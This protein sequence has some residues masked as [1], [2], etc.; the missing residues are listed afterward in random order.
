MKNR[1]TFRTEYITYVSVEHVIC[2]PKSDIVDQ[3]V[4][5]CIYSF[6]NQIN[7]LP[8]ST[9]DNIHIQIH[10]QKC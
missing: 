10:I 4:C 7:S 2:C 1:S 5:Y 6:K 3:D 9:K 8:L